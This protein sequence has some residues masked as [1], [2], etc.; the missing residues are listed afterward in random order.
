M[1]N[2]CSIPKIFG[3]R[4]SNWYNREFSDICHNH[5]ISYGNLHP[6]IFTRREADWRYRRTV[7]ER[8]HPIL[9][10]TVWIILRLFGSFKWKEAE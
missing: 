8:G 9:A 10:W 2:I 3:K 4:F 5:D 7:A 6:K 1:E